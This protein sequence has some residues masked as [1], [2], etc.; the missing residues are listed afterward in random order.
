[1]NDDKFKELIEQL[2]NQ[3]EIIDNLPVDAQLGTLKQ[4]ELGIVL[5]LITA[6]FI[7][8]YENK[9]ERN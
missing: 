5:K 7:L 6:L 3:Y 2:Q 4:Y 9:H 8:V 1:M